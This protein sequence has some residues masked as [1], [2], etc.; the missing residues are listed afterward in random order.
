MEDLSRNVAQDLGKGR[1]SKAGTSKSWTLLLVGELGNIVSFRLS[2]TSLIC[3]LSAFGVVFT[4]AVIASI[5]YFSLRLE[6]KTLQDNLNVVTSELLAANNAREVSQVRLML[7]EGKG[8][9]EKKVE[10]EKQTLVANKSPSEPKTQPA[11]KADT[12]KNLAS[13]EK[14]DQPAV[15][16]QTRSAFVSAE[17]AKPPAVTSAKTDQSPSVDGK[18]DEKPYPEPDESTA[19]V[20]TEE[21]VEDSEDQDAEDGDDV[22]ALATAEDLLVERLEIW[23]QEGHKAIKF[24][25]SLKNVGAAGKKIKGYTFVVL[26]P[27][28]GSQEL[29]RG[30][31]WT[32]LKDGKPT[33]YKR[34]QFFSIA[35]FK[36]VRGTVP[37]IQDVARFKTATIFVFTESGDLLTEKVFDVNDI[38]RS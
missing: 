21:A 23:K 31:P 16:K 5:T 24:Q 14:K 10:P 9:P 18:T 36:Y 29:S 2:R 7:L 13:S 25:F 11:K 28:E 8:R 27:E 30:S 15:E 26:K 34:G 6:N 1:R 17:A 37:Q 22:V 4:F 20:E 12:E 35:R 3:Y 32:P 33:I 38:L 19:P